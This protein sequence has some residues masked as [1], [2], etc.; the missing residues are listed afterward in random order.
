MLMAPTGSSTLILSKKKQLQMTSTPATAPIQNAPQ[1]VQK[2]EG[3]VM[4]TNPASRQLHIMPGS[5]FLVG[6]SHH[7]YITPAIVALI[8]ANMVLTATM[9]MRLSLAA[10]ELPGLNPNQPKA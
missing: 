2:P 6:P 10:K 7:I 1:G 4:A 3:A 9:P 8:P 5:G